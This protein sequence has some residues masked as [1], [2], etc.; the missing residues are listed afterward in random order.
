M[1]GCTAL[2]LQAIDRID[3]YLRHWAR[4][5]PEAVAFRFVAGG[6]EKEAMTFS[7]LDKAARGLSAA[8]RQAL[9]RGETAVL[10][11][12]PGLEFIRSYFACLY[13]D[14]VPVPIELPRNGRGAEKLATMAAIAGTRC[15]LSDSRSLQQLALRLGS[16]IDALPPQ[17]IATD[18]LASSNDAWAPSNAADAV[19]LLQLTSGSTGS[20]K[21]V[22]VTH[23]QIVANERMIARAF[24]HDDETVVAGW[25]PFFH[26]MGLIGN[27]LQPV[28]LGRPCV[29]MAPQDFIQQPARWLQLISRYQATTSGGPNFAYA[30]AARKISAAALEDGLDLSRWRLAFNGA[31]PVRSS[32]LRDFSARF[33]PYGF[34]ADAFFPCYGLAEATLFVSGGHWTGSEGDPVCVGRPAAATELLIVDPDSGHALPD[35]SLGEIWIAGPCVAPGYWNAPAA[36]AAAFAAESPDVPGRRWLRT[37][38]LGFLRQGALHPAGRLKDLIIVRGANHHAEDIEQTVQQAWPAL[39]VGAVAA[40]AVEHEDESRLVVALEHGRGRVAAEHVGRLLQMVRGAVAEAQGLQVSEVLLLPLGSLPRT[41]SGKLRRSLCRDRY[42]AGQW[43]A[44]RLDATPA[45]LPP[46]AGLVDPSPV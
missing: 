36:T 37:G 45:A 19:A 44:H 28:F 3:G 13:A 23:R 14:V 8:L 40:F 12:A 7:E 20:P 11:Y 1:A 46:H 32:T 10:S 30:L 16:G 17:R 18:Q 21:G 4:E 6:I 43:A 25:L 2:S 5:R 24:G 35:G 38:D 42:L 9:P 33:R 39:A 22:A 27:I 41:S 15:L 31:E 34:R 29:L 26:D